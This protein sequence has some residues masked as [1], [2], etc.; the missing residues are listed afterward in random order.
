MGSPTSRETETL[1]KAE[2]AI[3]YFKVGCTLVCDM[4]P[5]SGAQVLRNINGTRIFSTDR[6]SGNIFGDQ[7]Q[8][9]LT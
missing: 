9:R 2:I 6:I 4:N 5:S 8:F 3:L 7:F 1:F